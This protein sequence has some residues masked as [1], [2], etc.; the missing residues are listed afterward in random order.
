MKVTTAICGFVIA[1]AVTLLVARSADAQIKPYRLSPNASVSQTVGLTDIV[2]TYSRPGVKGREIWGKLLPY[3]KVWRA[4]ANDATN[5]TFSD[6]VTI[7]GKPVKAGS[8]SFFVTPHQGDWT[9]ILNSEK[10]WGAFRYDSTKDILKYQVKPETAPLEER[11]SYSFTDLTPT[12]VKLVLRW[13][14]VSIAVPIEIATDANLMR[15]VKTAVA[16]TWQEYRD[17]ALF[18]LDSKSNWDKGMESVEKSIG[19]N[20]NANNLR[21]KAELLAQA[22]KSKEAIEVGTKAITVGKAANPNFDPSEIEAL[23]AVWKKK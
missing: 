13:E 11:L 12:S 5:I 9:V 22:G 4:G 17:H 7:A 15:A 10:Q 19:I 18:C 21:V 23:L 1:L 14:K 20:E 3:D 8:Y 6:D 16:S 2:V